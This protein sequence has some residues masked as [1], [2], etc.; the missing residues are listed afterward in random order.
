M[1]KPF[2]I[3]RSCAQLRQL[4][5]VAACAVIVFGAAG[6][7]DKSSSE[8]TSSSAIE[9]SASMSVA[10]GGIY[11]SPNDDRAYATFTL[12]N[13]LEVI[14]VSDKDAE[15]AAVS[16]SVGV[17]SYQDPDQHLG[18]AHYLEHMLFLGTEKYPE[19]N[20]LQ[21]FV[22]M[23]AGMWNA[24]TAP[25]LTNYFFQI[26][27]DKLAEA[28]D[29]FSDY[30]VSPKFD[31]TF[32]DKERNAVNSEWSMGRTNDGW[33]LQRV[34]G[35]TANPKNPAARLT[36]GNL[37]TLKDSETSKL[38]DALRDFYRTYYSAN[39]MK[40]VMVSNL[41]LSELTELSKTYFS[42]IPNRN[43]ERPSVAEPGITGNEQGQHIY[44]KSLKDLKLLQVTFPIADNS[45]EWKVKPNFYIENILSSEEPGTLGEILRK[46]GLAQSVSV[47]SDPSRYGNDGFMSVYITLTDKGVT[48]KDHI[49]ASV[50]SYIELLKKD[51]VNNT[52]FEEFKS[53][54]NKN[55]TDLPKSPA[56]DLATSLSATLFDVPAANVLNADFVYEKFDQA[57]INRVLAQM[58][59]ERARIFHVGINET[60][61]DPVPYYE[62][63]YRVKKFTAEELNQW[64]EMGKSMKFLL[65]PKNDLLAEGNAPIVA[66]EYAKPTQI[67]SEKGIEAF[68]AQPS[69]Y[70]EDKGVI[71][72]DLNSDIAQ[73]SI[74]QAAAA[75]IYVDILR[76]Q[77]MSLMDK[78]ARAGI[79]IGL[80]QNETGTL[81][82]RL[83]GYTQKHTT[84]LTQLLA[85]IKQQ[86][87][88][89]AE[90]IKARESYV[91]GLKNF[92]Q[93]PPY[94]QAFMHVS[95][96]LSQH[97][98]W[99]PQQ[100]AV[101]AEKLT[102]ESIVKYQ[103][104]LLSDHL[105]R[106]YVFGNYTNAVIK[107]A[108]LA[109][110]DQLGSARLPEERR[111]RL[112]ASPKAQE[113]ILYS[114]DILPTDNAIVKGF[115]GT[116]ASIANVAVTRLI[117]AIFSTDI[118]TQLRTQEQLG[119][120]VGSRAT[121]VNDRPML[122]MFAQSNNTAL[123]PLAAR[124]DK[125]S[126]DFIETVAALSD[127]DFT[128]L[129][130]AELAVL[131]EKPANFYAESDLYMADFEMGIYSF[132]R[133]ARLTQA[134]ASTK[135]TDLAALYNEL[136]NVER[137]ARIEIQLRGSNFAKESFAP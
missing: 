93:N 96:L 115:V 104:E 17:G 20:S 37:E 87:I 84:L 18:L 127:E 74:E 112:L 12:P 10:D 121:D 130:K 27:A 118:F 80:E 61:T 9:T 125:F 14:V 102:V 77:E 85:S 126:T 79:N 54:L 38:Q 62:G 83:G 44:I 69:F 2:A 129:Q 108:L 106:V 82:I 47:Y 65:P 132:D 34:T 135:K 3:V 119:Y 91:Q 46:E 36:V 123:I 8:S 48:Q 133:R 136:V 92:S 100:L 39:I 53:I 88:T 124:L 30:F 60:A 7:S 31:P 22:D 21:K 24:Y 97:S 67:L 111:L 15:M 59:P 33:I 52:Y 55:F 23:N 72:I 11:K 109:A 101:A 103:E 134:L 1:F 26:K 13:G 73:R 42:A 90:F 35:L 6:C 4:K 75:R 110:R 114:D 94:S 68:L 98:R 57:A 28:L 116:E 43:V 120:V 70:R 76:Q 51:G 56:L 113:R 95:R 86:G 19:P 45:S 58:T 131:N 122:L 78:A 117:N 41:P 29:Y 66:T 99:T 137:S 89:E 64:R 81:S 40:L 71:R 107:P 49:I 5:I 32:A 105:L 63:A 16:L 50:F 128:Q 25:E